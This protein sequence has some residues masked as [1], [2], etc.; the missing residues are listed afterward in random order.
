LDLLKQLPKYLLSSSWLVFILVLCWLP[1][2]AII[3]PNWFSFPNQDKVIHFTLF[4]VWVYFLIA[5]IHTKKKSQAITVIVSLGAITALGTE[6][7]QPIVSNRTCDWTD[8]AADMA[9]LAIGL[10]TFR[11][12]Q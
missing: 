9:G 10:I 4:F 12:K 3:E 6:Y 7:L 11:K 8:G 1:K 2:S 5:D